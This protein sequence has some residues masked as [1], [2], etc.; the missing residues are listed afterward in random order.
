MKRAVALLMLATVAVFASSVQWSDLPAYEAAKALV[1]SAFNG[2][3]LALLAAL[4]YIPASSLPGALLVLLLAA[5]FSALTSY[6]VAV[7]AIRLLGK[8]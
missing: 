5:L 1:S 4:G 2:V 7:L 3:V 8:S 6:L